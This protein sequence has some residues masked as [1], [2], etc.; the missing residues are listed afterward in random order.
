MVENNSCCGYFSFF[1]NLIFN[2]GLNWPGAGTESSSVKTD[3]R[4]SVSSPA[5]YVCIKS[6]VSRYRRIAKKHL[7]CSKT[8]TLL[9]NTTLITTIISAQLSP[10]SQRSLGALGVASTLRPCCRT[11]QCTR[12]GSHSMWG[13]ADTCEKWIPAASSPSCSWRTL[14][15][16][17][18]LFFFWGGDNDERVVSICLLLSITS[19]YW[20][21]EIREVIWKSIIRLKKRWQQLCFRLHKTVRVFFL[22][23]Y[24]LLHYEYGCRV[25]LQS[26]NN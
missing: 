10:Q 11:H 6:A 16:W 22:L 8:Q 9:H 13:W 15:C 7:S 21:T 4:I 24:S 14:C 23:W 19:F 26:K 20:I 1:Y 2:Q 12:A 3:Q 25:C 5:P 17:S 18:V